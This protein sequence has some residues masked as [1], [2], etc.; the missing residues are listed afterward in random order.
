MESTKEKP[1]LVPTEVFTC[2]KCGALLFRKEQLVTHQPLGHDTHFEKKGKGNHPAHSCLSY[3]ISSC[4]PWVKNQDQ[5]ECKIYCPNCS[6]RLGMLH[7]Q[8]TQSSFTPR[9]QWVVPAIQF[10]ISR[11]DLKTVPLPCRRKA[12]EKTETAVEK[13]QE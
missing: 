4:P 10:P 11:I 5:V 6:T 8:G 12:E 2:G 1:E 13:E 3:F 7:W 9:G